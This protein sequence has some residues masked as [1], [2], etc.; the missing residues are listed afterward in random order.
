MVMSRRLVCVCG[1]GTSGK[2]VVGHGVGVG[3][4]VGRGV[5]FEWMAR[6]ACNFFLAKLT[7]LKIRTLI[8]QNNSINRYHDISRHL[9]LD[10]V[11][12]LSSQQLKQIIMAPPARSYILLH[13]QNQLIF[14]HLRDFFT[15][16]LFCY[17]VN[18]SPIFKDNASSQKK[19][20]QN[21]SLCWE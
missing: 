9:N 17:Q 10:K 4:A 21:D 8:F 12:A 1:D 2:V 16:M 7:P 20:I 5:N 18:H 13:T 19:S 11:G 3:I 14:L 6:A 15:L